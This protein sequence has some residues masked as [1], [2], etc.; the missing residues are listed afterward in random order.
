MEGNTSAVWRRVESEPKFHDCRESQSCPARIL[1]QFGKKALPRERE[2]KGRGERA[3]DAGFLRL[4][5]SACAVPP[6]SSQTRCKRGADEQHIVH[7]FPI[8]HPSPAP[9]R[10][11]CR[12]WRNDGCCPFSPIIFNV[13]GGATTRSRGQEECLDVSLP[14]TFPSQNLSNPIHSLL[15]CLLHLSLH[16]I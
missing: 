11:I 6:L 16:V 5:A 15:T 2:A 12:S 1:S 4:S 14:I 8:P 13:A 7:Y 3:S 10:C 9:P